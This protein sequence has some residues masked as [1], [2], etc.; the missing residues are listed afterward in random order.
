MKIFLVQNF[1]DDNPYFSTR[2]IVKTYTVSGDI[3][4]T[5]IDWKNKSKV[6]PCTSVLFFLYQL[7]SFILFIFKTR[8]YAIRFLEELVTGMKRR[9]M[10]MDNIRLVFKYVFFLQKTLKNKESYFFLKK[11]KNHLYGP[12][13]IIKK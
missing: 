8:S 10:F 4:V 11:K 5:P 13:W 1:K 7:F 3:R 12:L 6:S 2:Q 9:K